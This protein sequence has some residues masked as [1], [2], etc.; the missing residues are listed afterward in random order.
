[1]KMIYILRNINKT[2]LIFHVTNEITNSENFVNKFERLNFGQIHI[3]RDRL[4]QWLETIGI[5]DP[6]ETSTQILAG[7]EKEVVH[8]F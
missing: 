1:M 3:E 8:E 2:H 6:A 4:T 7:E 5:E